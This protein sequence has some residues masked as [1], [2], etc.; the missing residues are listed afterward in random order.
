MAIKKT[1]Q[2]LSF[3]FLLS[4]KIF[5]G[6]FTMAENTTST[7]D[8]GVVLDMDSLAGKMALS[9][10]S[11]ALSDFYVT[12]SFYKT[13]LVLHTRDSKQD[14]IGAASAAIDLI[15]NVEV[16]A[17]IG[18]QTSAQAKF[19]ADL[20]NTIQVPIISFSATS[21]S[22]SSA[23]TPYFVRTTQNDS[24]QAK[25]ITAIIQAFGWKSVVP[26][27]EDTEYGKDI[28]PYLIE[29]LQKNDTRI[30]YRSVI[31]PLASDDQILKELYKL[32]TMQT[33]VF[34]VHMATSL[35]SRLFLKAEELGMMN[36]EYVWILTDGLSNAL[37]SMDSSVIG[38]M[39]GALGIRAYVPISK[40]L[41]DFR[42]K[43][44]RKFHQDNPKIEITKPS[45][46]ELQAYDTVFA[47]AM[48]VEE[49]GRTDS[50]F[51]KP[52]SSKISDDFA[53]IGVSQTGPKLLQ[54]ILNSRFKGLI[55]DFALIDGQLQSSAFQI[56]NLIGDAGR[57]IGFWT[58]T[59][60]ISRKL[61][62]TSPS[63]NLTSKA[64][65]GTIIW[66]GD[67]TIVPKGWVIPTNGKKL[68]IGVPVKD[69]FSEFVKVVWDPSTNST[70]VTGY[71]I[72]VFKAVIEI[73]P[74]AVPYEF[75]PFQNAN[76]TSAGTY[77]D[78]I[79]QVYLQNYDAVVGD[80]TIIANRSMYVDFTLP[81]TE[82][83]VSMLVP[84][85]D[86]RKSAWI[87]LKPLSMGL[88][89]TTGAFFIFTGFVIW[90]LEHR[91]NDDFRGK[92]A[93]HLGMILWFSFSTLVFALKEKVVS[94]YARFVVIIWVFVVLIITS[95]YTANLTSM[96]TVQRLQP[97]ALSKNHECV[98][99]QKGSF[100]LGLL[101]QLG[102]DESFLK[103]YNSPEEF[104]GALSN[105]SQKGG[106]CAV[107]DEV[108]YLDLLLARYCGKYTMVG[109]TYKTDGFGFAFPRGSLLARD[110]SR[111]ILNVTQGD[112]MTRITQAWFGRQTSC[113]D[114]PK[115]SSNSLSLDSFWG[116]FVIAMVSTVSAL[117]I[118][119]TRFFYNHRYLWR[120]INPET[121][122][123]Q[124]IVIMGRQ[125][126]KKETESRITPM[127]VSSNF[128]A[129]P[130]N[131]TPASS[132]NISNLTEGAFTPMDDEYISAHSGSLIHEMSNSVLEL[133]TIGSGR[134]STSSIIN[135]GA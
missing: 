128:K 123:W 58:P 93:N 97:K 14:V 17:I 110:I 80:T 1:T 121:S 100:V 54:A 71:C 73:L 13:R 29:A 48:A 89:F 37:S 20:G 22:L 133:S 115:S 84:V 4:S 68:R 134:P 50:H 11:I 16:Q 119:S 19:M 120:Q 61:Q 24:S 15:Q 81:F 30:P 55:G 86:K 99:Y 88:W 83:G 28:L 72:D 2:I 113:S 59:F 117:L 91:I 131:N 41:S 32:M 7:F 62:V 5:L 38:L 65:L 116:L 112:R 64:N 34:V 18:P 104:D 76:G 46:F 103:V 96:L 35:A 124:K 57:E 78:L 53:T 122:L 127:V 12:H 90:V 111:A 125:F 21:P 107:F 52:I 67:S 6:G 130:N 69:G 36:E 27:Y 66:P 126:D 60:G 92:P 39:Q 42:V 45:V 85:I 114:F 47:L 25:P 118:F 132:P 51:L 26:I 33:R 10:I 63:R 74:Y 94:N 49:V 44:S 95:S 135:E 82:S 105:G 129:S 9:S 109:P 23:R 98:G 43:W 8:V 79:Y 106:V 101:K 102:Y 77:N 40:E 31:P 75:V 56:L 87:F 3:F 108:P 70:A